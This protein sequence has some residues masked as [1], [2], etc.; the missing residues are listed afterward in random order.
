MPISGTRISSPPVERDV[1]F[2]IGVVEETAHRDAAGEHDGLAI[3]AGLRA[4]DEDFAAG[5][6]IEALRTGNGLQKRGGAFGLKDERQLHATGNTDG[7]AVVLGDGDGDDRADQDLFL[8]KGGTDGGFQIRGIEAVRHQALFEHG[9][10]K[11]A[12][13]ADADGA[14]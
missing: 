8:A 11:I 2:G 4:A 7:V 3:G 14:A 5:I 9:K 12:I 10:R 6:R 13:G 1:E